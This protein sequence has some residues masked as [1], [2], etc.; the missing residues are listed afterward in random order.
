[1]GCVVLAMLACGG[2]SGSNPTPPTN[3]ITN[4][5][6]TVNSANPASAVAITVSPADANGSGNGSTS[7]TRT[8]A[9]GASVTLTAAATSGGNTFSSWTGCATASAA[10]CTVSMT[11]NVTVTANYSTPAPT[12]YV[13]TVNSSNPASGVAIIVSPA[14]VNASGNGST[15]FTRTYD[16]GAAVT[17][18]APM[19]SGANIFSSWTGC[20]SASALVCMVSVNA[21]TTVTANYT[22]PAPTTYVLT[23]KSINPA[24]GLAIGILPADVN[25]T[26]NGST[27]FTRTY[28][29]GTSV[30]LTAPATSGVNTFSSWTGCTSVTSLVCMI[31]VN[32]NATVTANYAIPAPTTYVL[33]VNSTNPASG[34]AI[35]VAP[36]DVN[37]SGNGTTSFTRTYAAAANVTLTAATTSS[38]GT[39]SSWSGCTSATNVTCAVTLNA[40]TTVTANYVANG[41]TSVSI[42]PNPGSAAIGTTVQFAA[43][44]QGNG[45]FS[46]AVTWS[47]SAPSGNAGDI[48]TAGLYTTPSP[49]PASVTITATSTADATKSASISLTLAAPAATTGPALMVDAG[50]QT[51]AIS[52]LIYG[53][54]GYDLDT[55]TIKNANVS[56][57]RWG[58]DNVSRYN[59][60]ANTTNSAADYYFESGTGAGGQWPD[61]SFNGVVTQA[62]ALGAEIVGTAPV[63]GWVTTSNVA[64]SGTSNP[65]CSFQKATFP[66][67]QSYNNNCGN[68]VD[69]NGT[70]L[71]GNNT[72]AALTSM[73]EPPP[74]PPAAGTAVGPSWIGNWV[75]SLTTQFGPGNPTTG[76]GKGVAHWDLDNEPEYWSAVHRDVHPLPMTYDEIT[77]GGIGTALAIKTADP[78]A[79]VSG[80][81][82]SGWSNYFDSAE[83]TNA[84]YGTAPCYNTFADPVDRQ[85]HGGVPLIEY[86]LQQM[87]AAQTTYGKR[88]LDYV[89]IHTYFAANYNNTSTGLTAAGD[90]SEQIARLNSTRVFWDPT[91]TDPNLPTPVYPAPT[92]KAA[93]NPTLQA[94]EVIPM[95]QGWIAK[96]YPGT[97]TSIDEYNFGGMEAINGALA[98]ADI[99]GIF[100]KYGL[101]KA[102]LWPTTNYSAQVPGTEAFAIYRN[103]DGADSGFGNM[104]L[105]STTANQA[106][107][108]VYGAQRTSDGAV[109][110]VVI[111]KTYGDLSSTLTL[112]NL[113]PT[114]PA[115]VYLYSNANLS[116]IVAQPAQ[117]LTPPVS[118][119]T[120][121]TL[122]MTFPAQSI[123]LLVVPTT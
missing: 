77:S 16:S 9:S 117:T 90:T 69:A 68:G 114:G 54:N 78:T 87:Q 67:Q 33:T 106:Q 62:A 29:A 79:L 47:V 40:N 48:S 118:P 91:Y 57:I 38:T 46:N 14:D 31:A 64:G 4:Y 43:T 75:T 25:N 8:Y 55:T 100:G 122:T 51:R 93:C 3:P 10:T 81:V 82:I 36:A 15:S 94:P 99:L 11:A 112:P 1:V 39:F 72:I 66:N 58:G 104:A 24:S 59:Y 123:T 23:I 80:P 88:L 107:L 63:I 71:V 98:Q 17:L 41:V 2:S 50:T 113:T 44:V 22:T 5:T 13:L 7:F 34:I 30:M 26:G 19:T 121:D 45:S 120:A 53:V 70:N 119:A 85:A 115:K 89:D 109:T 86:Y 56:I 6:L 49:A 97:K 102:M 42:S 52:P 76:T 20:T 96:D 105:S 37:S 103:Y 27:T 95:L 35:G 28:A 101:D 61:G 21:N 83:D 110:I 108:S 74:T 92:T 65:A 12:T 116:A 32:A 84:G 18:T 60:V 111:N 73:S